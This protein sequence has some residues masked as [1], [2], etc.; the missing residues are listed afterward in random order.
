MKRIVE[1]YGFGVVLNSDGRNISDIID[2]IRKLERNYNYYKKNV[3]QNSKNIMW[4]LQEGIFD[5][6]LATI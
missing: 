6:L 2:G 1:K 5:N 3:E 4:D